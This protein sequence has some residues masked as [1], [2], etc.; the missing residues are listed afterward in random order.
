MMNISCAWNSWIRILFWNY[1]Y[2]VRLNSKA[3]MTLRQEMWQSAFVRGDWV[4]V[5]NNYSFDLGIS[6]DLISKSAEHPLNQTW[7]LLNKLGTWDLEVQI[8]PLWKA[9]GW[10][11]F[12]PNQT[13]DFHQP[14]KIHMAILQRGRLLDQSNSTF[15]FHSSRFYEILLLHQTL[16]VSCVS[17]K[18]L[19]RTRLR[20]LSLDCI[21]KGN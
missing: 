8:L 18:T 7:I 6:R 4:L 16:S 11:V 19:G 9:C 20:S 2:E 17:L 13:F 1:K 14:R 10:A 12:I 3:K 5:W 15:S 21:K